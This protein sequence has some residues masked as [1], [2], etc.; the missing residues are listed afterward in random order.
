MVDQ[1]KSVL[2][3]GLNALIPKNSRIEVNVRD[4][5]VGRDTGEMGIIASIDITKI[6]PNPFQPRIDFDQESLAELTR[7]IQ[8]KGIIQPITVRRFDGAYQLISGER[9]LR[10]VQAARL[11]QIPA[12]IIAVATDEEM[13]ELA[14]IENI[15]REYLNPMEIANA[16]QRLIDEC[17][18]N[19]ED[20]AK[21]VGKDRSTVTNFIRLLKLPGKIQ[22]GLRK[23]NIS[24]GHARALISLP[25]ERMQ[26]RLFEKIVDNGLSVRKVEDIVRAAQQPKKKSGTHKESTG[27]QAGIQNLEAQLRQALGTKVKVRTK[28]QGRGEIIVEYYSLDDFDRLMDLFT[29]K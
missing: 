10:A 29:G 17:H 15:Q 23:E 25:N 26:I 18:I 1:K 24:M 9:R 12:Y 14:L 20:I 11:R 3:R 8:E 6:R 16:Y 5:S 27:T 4:G 7:S 22:E 13:L 19:Q 28:G 2:G 21:R